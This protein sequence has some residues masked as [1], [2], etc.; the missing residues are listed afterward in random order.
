V[1]ILVKYVYMC[2]YASLHMRY[3]LQ[4]VVVDVCLIDRVLLHTLR[5]VYPE[6]SYFLELVYTSIFGHLNVRVH[7]QA[8]QN[9]SN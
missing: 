7:I 1:F 4:C 2:N 6:V 8:Q 3:I 5:K 9:C